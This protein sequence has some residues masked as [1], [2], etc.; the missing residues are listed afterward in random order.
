MKPTV[1][2]VVEIV[3]AANES[4]RVV[5]RTEVFIAFVD[6]DSRGVEAPSFG[7]YLGQ[8]PNAV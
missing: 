7:D 6:V 5:D 8:V 3:P 2:D 1:V 4:A